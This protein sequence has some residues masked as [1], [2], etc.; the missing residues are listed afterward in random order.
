MR[1]LIVTPLG[2]RVPMVDEV[3]AKA[4]AKKAVEKERERCLKYCAQWE[5]SARIGLCV[6]AV[7]VAQA[8]ASDIR[9]GE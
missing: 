4:D 6:N 5:A 2:A 9:S 7:G 3:S 8:I 1:R